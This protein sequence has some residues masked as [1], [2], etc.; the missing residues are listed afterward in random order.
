ME[1]FS[2]VIVAGC[3]CYARDGPYLY[4]YW[5]AE[6]KPLGRLE[7]AQVYGLYRPGENGLGLV[8]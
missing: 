2:D 4:G 1:S 3:A 8:M 5:R 7:L 6:R